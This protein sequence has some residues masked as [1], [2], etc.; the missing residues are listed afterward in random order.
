LHTE[1][2]APAKKL[3]K[4]PQAQTRIVSPEQIIPL[5]EDNFK[6]F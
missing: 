2:A 3:R 5:D 6:E 4:L 1:L